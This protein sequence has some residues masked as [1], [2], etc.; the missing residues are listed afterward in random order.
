[1]WFYK[2]FYMNGGLLSYVCLI[3]ISYYFIFSRCFFCVAESIAFRFSIVFA[4]R[5]RN[6]TCYPFGF[7]DVPTPQHARVC[8]LVFNETC[9][10]TKDYSLSSHYFHKHTKYF[11]YFLEFLN[12]SRA[13]CSYIIEN[14]K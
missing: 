10:I 4:G 6:Y 7:C 8:L 13:I 3:F 1:M 5:Y 14:I 9:Y 11:N 2:I 12:K